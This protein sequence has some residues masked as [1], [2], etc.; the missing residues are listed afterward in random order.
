MY[1]NQK[2][3]ILQVTGAMNRGGAETM[4]MNLFRNLK[5]DFKFIFLVNKKKG[6]EPIGDYDEEIFKLGGE[7]LYIDAMWD[8][9]I[10]YYIKKFKEIISRFEKIDVV[11]SHL[12]S[13]G[14]VIAMA[15]R[16]GGINHVI[17]HSHASLKFRGSVLSRSANYIELGFQR[18]LIN[19]YATDFWACAP[20]AMKSL[21]NHKNSN[22][23][24]SQIINN[25]IDLDK[26]LNINNQKLQNI[27]NQLDLSND[28][29]IIGTVGRIAKVKNYDFIMELLKEL[30]K[31][32]FL[33][34]FLFVGS[35]QDKEYSETVFSKIQEYSLN[36]KVI[37]LEPR[38]D[39][40]YIYPLFDVFI[41]PSIR[42]GLGMVAIEAQASGIPCILSEGFPKCVDMNL[43]LTD[44]ISGYDIQDWV[45]AIKKASQKDK[46]VDKKIILEA[47]R[48]N[49]YDITSEALRVKCLY[50]KEKR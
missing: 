5:D 30:K 50:D 24:N 18:Y 23:P 27:R 35:K 29:T 49:G 39:L 16:K 31:H 48:S 43:S 21:F 1:L 12:N 46:L 20:N 7:I 2:K 19:K 26:F 37:Y 9:G 3:T 13:K 36:D 32:D 28:Y 25:A 44:F 4:L 34:R 42:E 15:A 41:S 40:E 47:F 8:I 14:G 33:F 22:S 45:K 11:H 10:P 17:V 6:L 38:S